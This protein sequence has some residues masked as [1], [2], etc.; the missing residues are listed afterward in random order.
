MAA[1]LSHASP[2]QLA[3]RDMG[4]PR[5]AAERLQNVKNDKANSGSGQGAEVCILCEN[6]DTSNLV[7]LDNGA[8]VCEE[9]ADGFDSK[10]D[11]LL[12]TNEVMVHQLQLREKQN[13]SEEDDKLNKDKKTPSDSMTGE[14][15]QAGNA[16]MNI[17]GSSSE[18][19]CGRKRKEQADFVASG[20][21]VESSAKRLKPSDA[22]QVVL[23]DHQ[24]SKHADGVD[25]T[26]EVEPSTT[27]R[28][29]FEPFLSETITS[30]VSPTEHQ[31]LRSAP[32]FGG[33]GWTMLVYGPQTRRSSMEHG[34]KCQ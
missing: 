33:D 32:E 15:N 22:I 27:I 18:A 7:T 11:L 4:K 5:D 9:C 31:L 28:N 34:V 12:D 25:C 26:S 14:D 29:W 10:E 24:A 23:A 16:E 17:S 19:N 20:R 8:L 3:D 1:N 6:P 30:D 13:P 2:S 21:S